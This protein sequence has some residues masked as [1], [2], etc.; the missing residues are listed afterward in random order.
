MII[1]AIRI[2]VDVD[3]TAN[4]GPIVNVVMTATVGYLALKNKLRNVV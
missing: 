1:Q 2:I 3:L 4:A